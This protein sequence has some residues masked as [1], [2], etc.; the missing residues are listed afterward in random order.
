M[1]LDKE[2][3]QVVHKAINE[4]EGEGLITS[5]QA[6][7][8]KATTSVRKNDRQQIAQYFFFIALFC[9]LLAF[10]AIFLSEK[11]LE[12]IKAYFSWSDL[13][14]AGISAILSVMW[15]WYIGRKR[16][17]T[18]SSAYEIYMALGGLSVLTSLVYVCKYIQAD[19][20][21]YTTFLS[22]ATFCLFLLG[23]VMGSVVL[24]LGA[25]ITFT[26]WFGALTS[27]FNVHYLFLGMNYPVRYVLFGAVLLVLSFAMR[28][29]KRLQFAQSLTYIIGLSVFFMALWAVSIFGN[30]N[31]IE[32][33]QH[34]HQLQIVVYSV[35]LAF[36]AGLS[37]YLGIKYRDNA[38]RD[39]GVLF[40]LINLYT[41]YFEYFWDAMNKGIFFLILAITFG[42]LGRW[43]ERKSKAAAK[44]IPVS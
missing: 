29:A 28:R 11:L 37:F 44:K 9:T 19:A 17:Q 34:V 7:A 6:S 4:W 22:L 5:E 24:W 3:I 25:L 27:A 33:W 32:R 1:E 14:I 18:R 15:F 40:L 38:A 23:A 10:G 21:Y 30:F 13:A 35:F 42:L 39:I 36:A 41:R 43:L 8:L 31:S 16:Q 20:T 26:C 12:R 2:E